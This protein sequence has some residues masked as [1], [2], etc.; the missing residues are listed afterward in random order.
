MGG[1][2]TYAAIGARLVTGAENSNSVGWIVDI[3]SDFPVEF[4]QT[5]ES[6][7]TDC[8]FREDSSRLTTRAWN[9]YGSEEHRGWH[10]YP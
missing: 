9:G 10:N 4:R 1:A 6:W 3:G 2:G 5:I 8:L 7:R